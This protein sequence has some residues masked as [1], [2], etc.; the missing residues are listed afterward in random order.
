MAKHNHNH[1][2]TG[3][4]NNDRARNGGSF[5]LEERARMAMLEAGFPVDL[6]K[7]ARRQVEA[8]QANFT[9]DGGGQEFRDMRD[10]PWSSIDNDDSL[11]LDQIEYA[12]KDGEDIRIF[13]GIADVDALVPNDTPVDDFAMKKTTS[14][15]TGVKVFHMLPEELS[16][17]MSSLRKNEDRMAVVVELTVPPDGEARLNG[18]HRALV[19]NKAKLTYDRLGDWLSGERDIPSAFHA[20]EGLEEQIRLQ[21]EAAERLQAYRQRA[22]MLD[23]ETIEARPVMSD[24]KVV[25]MAV[26]HKNQAR[27]IIENLMIAANTCTA[28]L[29]ASSGRAAIQRVVDTPKRWDRIVDLAAQHGGYLPDSPNAK[30]LSAF[31]RKA[32]TQDPERFPDL[33]LSIVKLLGRGEYA[34][35]RPGENGGHFGLA[36]HN[37]TH[38]TAPNRRYPDVISQ[39]LVKAVLDENNPP[40]SENDL[41]VLAAHC[42]EREDAANKVERLMRKVAAAVMLQEKIGE[43]FEG[44]ITGASFK[45]TWVRVKHPAVEGK[46]VKGERG[47]DVGDKVRVRLV[48]ADPDTGHVDFARA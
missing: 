37:Y 32:R 14:V 1:D 4:R 35:V 30:A 5:D 28:K 18:I 2:R 22:G 11:D 26:A 33:S 48:G 20:V 45:G 46:V 39:R 9:P 44:I 34:V 6:P 41:A 16:T 31:L 36:V 17:D 38:S 3:N 19:T 25:D 23:F 42:T 47:M 12:E 8:L 21:N 13:V 29:L 43:V 15:Y 27:L 10:L 24:G 7:A 40:Y